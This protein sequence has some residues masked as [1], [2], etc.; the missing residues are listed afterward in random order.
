MKFSESLKGQLQRNFV[1][2]VSIVIA[3]S[4]LSYNTWRNEKS[5]FNRNQRL[6]SL[7]VL[8]KL[9]ELQELV[10]HSFYDRDVDDLAN[11]RTGW[12]L[13]LTI[14][15]LSQVL[16]SPLPD[17]A[18]DLV[19]VWGEHW[20][21]LGNSQTSVDAINEGVQTVRDDTLMLLRALN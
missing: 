3:V 15:D 9:G 18:A 13:V 10:F 21:K 19:A 4:S 20:E 6:A 2:L 8:L 12:A 17:S 5:E 14:K 7:Q 1:A 16:E 11:P